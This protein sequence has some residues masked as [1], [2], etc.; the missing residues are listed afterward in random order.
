MSRL[1]QLFTFLI[2]YIGV[3]LWDKPGALLV[4]FTIFITAVFSSVPLDHRDGRLA[5]TCRPRRARGA[6]AVCR[7]SFGAVRAPLLA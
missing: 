5:A 3:G 2:V 4:Q 7:I 6:P 1:I